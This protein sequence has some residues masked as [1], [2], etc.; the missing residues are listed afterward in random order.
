M[1]RPLDCAILYDFSCLVILDLLY[2]MY[3]MCVIYLDL[4]F[5]GFFCWHS[6]IS[7]YSALHMT[8][9]FF[10][11]E[12]LLVLAKYVTFGA[13][14]AVTPDCSCFFQTSALTCASILCRPRSLNT[15]Q[16]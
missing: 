8:L 10:L 14:L 13:H 5:P 1:A 15:N 11:A 7:H 4:S 3:P 2:S 9:Q 16:H 12:L 6:G